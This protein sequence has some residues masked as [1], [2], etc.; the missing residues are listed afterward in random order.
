MD[1]EKKQAD[2][3]T[4]RMVSSPFCPAPGGVD[5]PQPQ[6]IKVADL[7]KHSSNDISSRAARMRH[8]LL[9]EDF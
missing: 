6:A 7:I 3:Q 8:A 5:L 9:T 4:P 1:N 2:Q